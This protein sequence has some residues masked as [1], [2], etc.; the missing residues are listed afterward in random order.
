MYSEL[1]KINLDFDVKLIFSKDISSTADILRKWYF[2][3]N[4]GYKIKT[5]K[6]DKIYYASNLFGISRKRLEILFSE[7]GSI[8]SIAKADKK[9]FKGIKSIGRKT[10]E[11]IMDVLNSNIFEKQN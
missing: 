3:K 5:L 11:K 7:F 1:F 6:Q 4:F 9:D 2:R 10:K 8:R